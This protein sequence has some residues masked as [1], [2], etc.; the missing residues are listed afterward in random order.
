MKNLNSHYENMKLQV[1]TEMALIIKRIS[2]LEMPTSI[3]NI[4][5]GLSLINQHIPIPKPIIKT[6]NSNKNYE[7]LNNSIYD[8]PA[9]TSCY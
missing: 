6:H 9:Q 2:Y 4:L 8:E 3:F 7:S 1:Q 5:I